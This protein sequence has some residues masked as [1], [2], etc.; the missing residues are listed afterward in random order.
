L[1]STAFWI[2]TACLD[3]SGSL[4]YFR[5]MPSS[6]GG[7]LGACLD[8]VPERV[9]RRLVRD[10]RDRVARVVAAAASRGRRW[11][12]VFFLAADAA[13]LRATEAAAASTAIGKCPLGAF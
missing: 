10:E 1:E 5:V 12:S 8:L 2:S 3:A 7:L 11:S 4:E 9:A 6:F 13:R